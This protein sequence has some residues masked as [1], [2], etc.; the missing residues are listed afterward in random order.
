MPWLAAM[1][2]EDG[3]WE[4]GLPK[5]A[6]TSDDPDLTG[7]VLLVYLRAGYTQRGTHPL[8]RVVAGGL[9]F[10]RRHQDA[11]GWIRPR[12][13]PG[14]LRDH[15]PAAQAVVE[16]YGMTRSMLYRE[17]ARSALEV[18]ARACEAGEPLLD[19]AGVAGC[20]LEVALAARVVDEDARRHREAPPF[21]V[22]LRR[23][24]RLRRWR[25]PSDARAG[26]DVA[27]AILTQLVFEG[28]DTPEARAALRTLAGPVLA[29]PL[30]WSV[31]P[32]H[33]APEDWAALNR[34]LEGV[35]GTA[36]DCWQRAAR[37]LV[38]DRQAL[39]PNG[40][41]RGGRWDPAMLDAYDGGSIRLTVACEGVL[42]ARDYDSLTVPS[43]SEDV[44][45]GPADSGATALDASR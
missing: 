24:D 6:A 27:N 8:A 23:F 14:D 39:L 4:D 44:G 25:Q 20:A 34:M 13:R 12:G 33:G 5:G 38:I 9:A 17:R 3:G 28:N 16:D 43:P 31:G 1:Q 41:R 19:D 22:D 26:R 29:S 32:P 42:Y 15:L 7:R 40:L 18:V 45:R 37:R 11:E 10:L 36:P 21:G 2:A 35:G 30:A